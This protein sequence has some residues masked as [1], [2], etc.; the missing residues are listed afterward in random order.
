M[1]VVV[2]GAG[3]AGLTVA[4]H[5]E[6]HLPPEVEIV[7]IDESTDH[8]L[9]HELHRVIRRPELADI[10]TIPLDTV[11]DRTSIRQA[12]V[13]SLDSDEQHIDLQDPE[14]GT[15]DTISYDY[16]AVCLGADTAYYDLTGVNS[17]ATPLK[18]LEDASAIRKNA[19]TAPNGTAI[20]GGAGLSGI[21]VA[22]ELAE[23]SR[24]E[25]LNLEVT[26]IEMAEHIA[27]SFDA[28]F[29]TAIQHELDAR[30]VTIETNT[31]ITQADDTTVHL[32]G[33]RTLAYDCFVWTGGIQGPR[34]LESERV[35]TG[36][37]LQLTDETF[38]LGDAA[39]VI[40]ADNKPVPATAQTAVR[41]AHIAA[42]NIQTL[43]TQDLT[44]DPG[45]SPSQQDLAQYHYDV[46]AWVV[47]VG[48]GAVAEIGPFIISGDP[49]RAAK[50]AIDTSYLSSVG[51]I[52]H[53]TELVYHKLNW[54]DVPPLDVADPTDALDYLLATTSDTPS[55]DATLFDRPL[56]YTGRLTRGE[57]IDLTPATR[58][59]DRKYPAS[60][61]A[62]LTH[63]L[64]DSLNNIL[65]SRN[66]TSSTETDNTP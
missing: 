60:P 3:Y 38:V 45:S 31:A 13:E 37:D 41:E 64:T 2:L 58:L 65:P 21:Q 27:P 62:R 48:D 1:R 11:L 14:D 22:G 6:R 36:S 66:T 26:L 63:T 29:A 42:D 5:L 49:A 9:Q 10:I 24:E 28:T 50:V 40:D 51:A 35:P 16:A 34:A 59:T 56:R 53:A 15:T 20:I 61:A 44:N 4:R 57:K 43:V 30:D 39:D 12:R 33:G 17:H 25:S 7:V 32:E 46:Q 52:K 18:R 8:L 47:T 19:F 55:I 54:P 23:L